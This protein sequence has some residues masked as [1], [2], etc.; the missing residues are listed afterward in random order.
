ME[1]KEYNRK[2]YLKNREAHIENVRNRQILTNY[3]AEKTPKQRKLRSIKRGTR[4]K[5]PL[6][7]QVCEICGIK[8]EEHHHFKPI[9]KDKFIFICHKCHIRYKGVKDE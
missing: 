6:K 5:Y 4:Q 9:N 3:S 1:K 7:N 8:A 2:W